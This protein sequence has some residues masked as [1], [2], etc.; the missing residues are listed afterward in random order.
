[1]TIWGKWKKEHDNV[2]A[3]DSH[4]DVNDK[5]NDGKEVVDWDNNVNVNWDDNDEEKDQIAAEREVVWLKAKPLKG[6][7]RMNK[8]SIR[9]RLIIAILPGLV[10]MVRVTHLDKMTCINDDGLTR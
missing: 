6:R 10:L 9:S 1:M 8:I 5:S 7:T 3:D 2:D 4:S